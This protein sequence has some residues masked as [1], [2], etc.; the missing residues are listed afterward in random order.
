MAES[1]S[2]YIFE[3]QRHQPEVVIP[4]EPTPHEFKQVSK[5]DETKRFHIWVVNFYPHNPL[6]LRTERDPVKIIKEALS[7]T[8]VFYYPLAGRLR[9]MPGSD[10]ELVVD[11]NGEGI[12]FTEAEANVTIHHFGYPIQPSYP[13]MDELL[14]N[15]PGCDEILNTPLLLIQVIN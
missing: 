13:E 4:A 11:C 5:T 1:R 3:V 12:L 2:T 7:Q 8:L 9:E 15:V 14:H 10:R 6:V